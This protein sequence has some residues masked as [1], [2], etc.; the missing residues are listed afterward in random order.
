MRARLSRTWIFLAVA[1][2]AVVVLAIGT[3]RRGTRDLFVECRGD[4]V[5]ESWTVWPSETTTAPAASDV[6]LAWD[7]HAKT[8]NQ[9]LRVVV[10]GDGPVGCNDLRVPPER[11]PAAL[12]PWRYD[13]RALD[14]HRR[15]V[16][17]PY[18]NPIVVFRHEDRTGRR[19]VPKNLLTATQLPSFVALVAIAALFV[20][21][22]RARRATAYATR[23]HA[24]T[25]AR[26]RPDGLLESEGG[27]TLGT[28]DAAARV[29][30]GAVL[31]DPKSLEGH[32]AYR[33]LPLIE[34]GRIVAGTHA[35]WLEGTARRMRDAQALA[36][37]ASLVATAAFVGRVLG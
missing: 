2:V 3:I 36:I 19:F 37:V 15:V 32:D 23:I 8:R 13:V 31:V 17:D 6:R 5:A 22:L 18:Q 29:P 4:L 1:A 27:T 21:V 14:G 30:A 7:D 16:V 10:A 25:E 26:L 34:R 33:A 11:G 9:D 35:R 24:W 20:G 28:V 12:S